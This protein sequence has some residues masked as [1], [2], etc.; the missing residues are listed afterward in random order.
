MPAL[1]IIFY[2][3]LQ[4][5]CQVKLTSFFTSYQLY[6]CGIL[7]ILNDRMIPCSRAESL[8]NSASSKFGSNTHTKS[9][10][11]TGVES[12]SD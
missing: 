12:P 4:V 9:Q 3:V 7:V 6:K 10:G 1:I 2:S 11:N 8:L 5:S